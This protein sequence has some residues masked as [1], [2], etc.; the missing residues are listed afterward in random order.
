VVFKGAEEFSSWAGL[1]HIIV[2]IT[3]VTFYFCILCVLLTS[4]QLIC[5][6]DLQI[7][8]VDSN[9]SEGLIT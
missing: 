7:Q 4:Q 1:D 8:F 2:Q 9:E 3:P 6:L 5:L